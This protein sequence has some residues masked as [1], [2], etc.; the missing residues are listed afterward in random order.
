MSDE[1]ASNEEQVQLL[2]SLRLDPEGRPIGTLRMGEQ[3]LVAV[4]G[5]LGLMSEI[6]RMITP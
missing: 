6:I 1:S 3:T 5:W 4:D 2:L